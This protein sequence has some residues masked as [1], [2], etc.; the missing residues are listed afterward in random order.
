MIVINVFKHYVW[1]MQMTCSIEC[2]LETFH[3]SKFQVV[4]KMKLSLDCR[5]QLLIWKWVVLTQ[6]LH[7]IVYYPDGHTET[8]YCCVHKRAHD[9]MGYLSATITNKSHVCQRKINFNI[10]SLWHLFLA[11]WLFFSIFYQ[12]EQKW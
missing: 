2:L 6:Q 12:A 4:W 5:F 9:I 8:L 10:I 1:R 11:F 3:Y 7:I